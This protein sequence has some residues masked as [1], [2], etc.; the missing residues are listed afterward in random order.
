MPFFLILQSFLSA[1]MPSGTLYAGAVALMYP[2][3]FFALLHT[4]RRSPADRLE[5]KEAETDM[6]HA[7]LHVLHFELQSTAEID[8][9]LRMA[10]QTCPKNGGHSLL[11]FCDLGAADAMTLPGDAPMLR[12]LQSGVMAINARSAC[13]ILLLARR[14]VWDDA[15]RAYLG[16]E[17][18]TPCHE[19]I[20]QLVTVGET[21]AVF[22][23]ATVTPASLKGRFS[24]VLFSNLRL[25]CTPDTPQRMEEALAQSD[26]PC[27]YARVLEN[28]SYPQTALSR[29]YL[30]A[31]FSLSPLCAARRDRLRRKGFGDEG[32]PAIY[33]SKALAALLNEPLSAAPTIPECFFV[34]RS[35]PSLPDLFREH[36]QQ[37]LYG[38][39]LH[40]M[41]PIV[42]CTLLFFCA[43][44]GLPWLAAL[45]LLPAE[46]W[47]L[48]HPRL[49]PGSL[50]RLALLPLT[51]CVSLDALLCRALA[52]SRLIRLRVPDALMTPQ[53]CALFG[54]A[55]LPA[56]LVS[57]QA[58]VPLLPVALL[59]LAAPL[60]IPALGTP[61]IERIPLSSDQLRQ[62]KA[63]AEST[64]FDSADAP[65]P[66]SVRMLAACAG[67]MLGLLE[68]DEAARQIQSQLNA[69]SPI[70]ASDC[71]AQLAA[72]QY[73]REN[74]GDCDAALR[75]LP[76]AIERHALTLP[77]ERSSGSLFTL[78]CAAR[79]EL[80]SPMASQ[81][82]ARCET[83][84]PLDLLFLPMQR[85]KDTPL[86]PV[87]LPLTHPHT[88][89]KRQLLAPDTAARPSDAARRFLFLAAAALGHPFHA[90]LM[91]SPVAGPYM[92]LLSA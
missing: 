62:I 12:K 52:R 45:A 65:C 82:L 29:L 83:P 81:R 9:I 20:A 8:V 68:P 64:F 38:K 39:T 19:I 79:Q 56:A 16:A 51:A 57:A 34:R 91:R 27:L 90:L 43:V 70:S 63:L 86:Y 75:E 26:L 67:S 32:A 17:Q 66:P 35:V 15:S 4:Y 48:A 5:K 76:A 87:S 24:S 36:R 28:R 23:A 37:C 80:S 21:S 40:A 59:W 69:S 60:I 10:R 78:L 55:L 14:R 13:D 6:D 77:L 84:E 30:C 92:P 89:L 42:Q 33:T 73:L 54:A 53:G 71:A 41:L 2:F 25:A 88:F 74:M 46:L 18:Q 7:L 3:L 11:L 31:P 22:D 47:A 1:F 85:S 50:L 44:T 49:L 72:A 61:T 58:L